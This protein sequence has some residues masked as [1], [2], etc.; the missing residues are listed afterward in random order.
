M[1]N[2]S[3]QHHGVL[4]MKWGIRRYQNKDGTLTNAGKKRYAKE[5][6]R[7]KEQ[8]QILKNKQKTQAKI[9]KLNERRKKIEDARDGDTKPKQPT[10]RSI[11]DLSEEELRAKVA[12]LELEKRYSDLMKATNP[13]QT[14]KAKAFV[15]GTLENAGKNIGTQLVTYILGS[16]VN[17]AF[18]DVFKDAAIVNPKKGQKDK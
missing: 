2:K 3:L 4:G 11:K 7:V 1:E 17:K 14:N 12:R 15:T 18:K 13:P 16:A 10:K 9:D 8:E 6:A 5:L